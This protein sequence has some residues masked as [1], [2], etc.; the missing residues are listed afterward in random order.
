M[1]LYWLC[2]LAF[3]VQFSH[4][5]LSVMI[6][7]PFKCIYG[8]VKVKYVLCARR[9]ETCKKIHA[10]IDAIDEERYD[11]LAKVGKADKEVHSS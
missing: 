1:S 3:Q 2:S 9:Q 8:C 4:S 6:F 10:L 5:G 11:V 7:K